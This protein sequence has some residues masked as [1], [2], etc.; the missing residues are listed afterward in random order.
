MLKSIVVDKL[1]SEQIYDKIFWSSSFL[2]QLSEF[3]L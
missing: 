3:N 1:S 2:L